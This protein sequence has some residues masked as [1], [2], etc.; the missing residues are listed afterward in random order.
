MGLADRDYMY[1][2]R[3][4]PSGRFPLSSRVGAPVRGVLVSA[5]LVGVAVAIQYVDQHGI[6]SFAAPAGPVLSFPQSGDVFVTRYADLRHGQSTF[7]IKVPPLDHSNYVVLLSDVGTGHR[8][9]AIYCRSGDETRVPVPVGTYR[10]R[11]ASGVD[12]YGLHNLF[13]R[14]THVEEVVSPMSATLTQGIGIDFHRRPDG[15]LPTQTM[16]KSRFSGDL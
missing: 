1:E 9:I 11:V 13:G 10:V 14:A 6:P 3:P 16:V 7:G 8:V 5:L 12:W 2:R 15:N 4:S